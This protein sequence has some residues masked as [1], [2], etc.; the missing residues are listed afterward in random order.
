[1]QNT[2]ISKSYTSDGEFFSEMRDVHAALLSSGWSKGESKIFS[3]IVTVHYH[4]NGYTTYLAFG[5]SDKIREE[6]LD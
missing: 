6:F 2:K 4:K 1:M 5:C 3:D